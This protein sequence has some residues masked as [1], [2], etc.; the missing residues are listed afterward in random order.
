MAGKDEKPEKPRV[1]MQ[2]E[3]IP[4]NIFLNSVGSRRPSLPTTASGAGKPASP[5]KDGK[6]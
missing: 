4:D 6:E 5:P 3:D 2:V 1:A